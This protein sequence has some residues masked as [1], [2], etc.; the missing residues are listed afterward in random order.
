MRTYVRVVHRAPRHSAFCFLDG[1][2]LPDELAAAAVELGHAALALTDH[3]GLRVDGVRA[4]RAA[5]GVR[6]IHGAEVTVRDHAGMASG[7]PA[8]DAAGTRPRGWANLCRL[9]T[10]PIAPHARR[11][12]RRSLAA[13]ADARRPR[14]ARRGARLPHRL[15][16]ARRA[17]R[18]RP[19][20]RAARARFGRDALPGGAAAPVLAPRP[21]LNRGLAHSPPARG[22]VRGDRQRPRPHAAAR[23]PAGRP[24]RRADARDARRAPSRCAAATTRPC[25]RPPEAM[26]A[27]FA[28]P[29]GRGR[30]DRAAGRAR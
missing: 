3:D 9:I 4:G 14:G 6:P 11:T 20:R 16:A 21:R 2:S 29:P 22:A 27:R 24:R 30:R 23:A 8:P 12:R 5:V 25:L 19:M 26:A 15:R 28:R 1:A 10:A 17:R 13:V 7:R 18:A